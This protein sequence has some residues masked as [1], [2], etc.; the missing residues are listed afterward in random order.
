MAIE[1]RKL[2]PAPRREQQHAGSERDN[3]A[4]RGE[5]ES[6]AEQRQAQGSRHQRRRAAR[7]RVDLAEIADP[8]AFAQSDEIQKMNDER[9]DHIRP[10]R[11]KR[12][13]DKGQQH[14]RDCARSDR[15]QRGRQ[16]YQARP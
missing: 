1:A 5:A 16:P 11:C 8:I 15:D 2:A 3:A 9:G 13:S 10:C 4:P 6:F 14:E 12:Q 7:Q